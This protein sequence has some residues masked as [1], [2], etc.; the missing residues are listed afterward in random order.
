MKNIYKGKNM[1]GIYFLDLQ[2]LHVKCVKLGSLCSSYQPLVKGVPQ[3]SILGPLLFNVFINDIFSFVT[4][5][6]LYNYADDNTLSYVNKDV[7][8]LVDVLERD[9][10]ALIQ[11]FHVNK[12]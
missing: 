7:D 2:L 10:K 1:T 6:S 9:S 4:D 8:I 11:W 12:M 3:G 5:G